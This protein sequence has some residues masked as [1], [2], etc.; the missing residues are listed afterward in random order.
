MIRRNHRT[1]EISRRGEPFSYGIV[2]CALEGANLNGSWQ[3][4]CFEMVQRARI[5]VLVGQLNIIS[6][7]SQY[8]F[9]GG[10][11]RLVPLGLH[12]V[13]LV[14]EIEITFLLLVSNGRW[15]DGCIICSYWRNQ[16]AP[17]RALSSRGRS[18]AIWAEVGH[19]ARSKRVSSGSRYVDQL[20][21]EGI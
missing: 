7:S 5:C 12:C 18:L 2:V 20:I 19:T 17:R 9:R 14:G 21:I 10:S 3:I 1:I 8:T 6:T 16:R 15:N 13:Y 4:C 11:G